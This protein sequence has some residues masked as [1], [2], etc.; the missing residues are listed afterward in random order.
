MMEIKHIRCPLCGKLS[1]KRN[2]EKSPHVIEIKIQTIGG[3]KN[4]KWH[5]SDDPVDKKKVV[6]FLI[7]S[8]EILLTSLKKENLEWQ[9]SQNILIRVVPSTSYLMTDEPSSSQ[10]THVT[11]ATSLRTTKSSLMK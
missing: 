11:Q 10:K 6:D 3:N 5:T 7:E 9:K 8:V 1:R 4:I 2:F